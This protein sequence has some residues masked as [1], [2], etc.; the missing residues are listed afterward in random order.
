MAEKETHKVM[1]V[2]AAA[3]RRRETICAMPHCR[4]DTINWL[5]VA[6]NYAETLRP[7]LI[8]RQS[9]GQFPDPGLDALSGELILRNKFHKGLSIIMFNKGLQVVIKR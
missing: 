8:R 2:L 3:G 9:C 6:Q 4:K 7:C 1:G 5:N